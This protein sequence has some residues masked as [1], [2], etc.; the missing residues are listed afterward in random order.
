MWK[1]WK[2]ESFPPWVIVAFCSFI[3]FLFI[4]TSGVNF[5]KFAFQYYVAT[6]ISNLLAND[7]TETFLMPGNTSEKSPMFCSVGLGHTFNYQP[8][9][10]N[11]DQ[12]FLSC[13]IEPHEPEML[14]LD[15]FR[16]VPHSWH[17]H[18]LLD[19]LGMSELSK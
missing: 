2:L 7:Y 9:S 13:F 11:F 8:V 4:I 10:L 1:L 15:L 19:S 14:N 6:K 18:V 16:H 5:V 12:A 17:V 3:Y